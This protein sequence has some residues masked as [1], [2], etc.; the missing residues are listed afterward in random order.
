MKTPSVVCIF[1]GFKSPESRGV[2][3]SGPFLVR[4]IFQQ[5]T[6]E[7]VFDLTESV[8]IE[9]ACSLRA[10]ESEYPPARWFRV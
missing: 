4:P 2:P 10:G 9:G 6:P 1:L 5:V 8:S 3:R 7:I